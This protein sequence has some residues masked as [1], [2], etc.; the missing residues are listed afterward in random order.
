MNRTVVTNVPKGTPLIDVLVFSG[1]VK[2]K[3]EARRLLRDGVV[4][5]VHLSPD[6]FEGVPVKKYE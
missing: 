2:S 5:P 3:T 4:R 6:F 1:L